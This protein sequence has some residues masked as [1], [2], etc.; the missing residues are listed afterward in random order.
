MANPM[1]FSVI[2]R[3]TL[4]R[5][6][7]V[8]DPKRR[9]GV[10]PLR[11]GA[12]R[13]SYGAKVGDDRHIARKRRSVASF[14]ALSTILALSACSN[15][16]AAAPPPTMT[17]QVA[18]AERATIQ[19][20]VTADAVLYPL[21]QAAIVAKISAPVAKFYVNRGTRVHA[22][23]VLADLE[24]K[25]LAAAVT[26]SRGAYDQAQAAYQTAVRSSLPEEM[27]KAEQDLK[28]AKE[29]F[30]AQQKV[31]GNRQT[32][33]RQG[34]IPRKDLEDATV[35]LVQAGNTYEL[36]QKH[37]DALK[38]FGHQEALKGAQ[39]ELAAAKGKYDA[40][41]A[42]LSYAEIRSP[43]EGVVTD[44]PLYVGEM[45]AAGS[46]LVT[47][48]DLSRVV[49]RAHLTG[50]QAALLKPGDEASI[51]VPG[52]SDDASA[53]VT[54]VSPALD[55]NSTT[56]E[57]WAE[58]PNPHDRLQPGSSARVTFVA[59]TVKNALVVP[60]SALVTASDGTTSVIVAGG[61][62]KPE[63]KKVK[64]GIRQGDKIQI[65][66][67]VEENDRVVTQ[68]AYELA[69]EDPDVLAK[70][71]LQIAEPKSSDAGSDSDSGK[72]KE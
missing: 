27:Q 1:R 43:I 4:A 52:A 44:R 22:G 46:P 34:A 17:V 60:A 68:G 30:D 58:A 5:R 48:M 45:A 6:S 9:R 21:R 63:Q 13:F 26:E 28:A 8:E 10:S 2:P 38:D 62:G 39:G 18:M 72:D 14:L 23:Q 35:A 49:A 53:K 36:A 42:Q 12:V 64:V 55:P 67:G 71:K 37:Y 41:E 66:E 19:H 56:V 50:E 31:V 47:V 16:E 61:D 59:K 70:T 7:A 51:S 32:L 65:T 54:V 57:V 3:A 11:Q 69:S 15:K 25:D 29:T 24:S 20:E 40:S 33:Y